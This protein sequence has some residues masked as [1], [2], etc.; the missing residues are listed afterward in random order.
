[1]SESVECWNNVE[2]IGRMSKYCRN[3]MIN[4]E[5]MGGKG[6]MLKEWEE[7]WKNGRRTSRTKRIWE[8]SWRDEEMSDESEGRNAGIA[9]EVLW[10]QGRGTG[11]RRH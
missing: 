2:I 10:G 1:M 5:I 6:T 8:V 4:L 9:G 7:R 3:K 11:T